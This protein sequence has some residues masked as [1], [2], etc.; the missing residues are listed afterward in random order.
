MDETKNLP[1]TEG[2]RQPALGSGSSS[3]ETK[4]GIPAVI[5]RYRVLGHLGEGGFDGSI[6]LTTTSESWRT[7]WS[8]F[9]MSE[10]GNGHPMVILWNR[11][12]GRYLNRILSMSKA[13][14]M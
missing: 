14:G 5:G 6:W 10:L 8:H 9:R 13:H 12:S 1:E 11:S 2:S 7:N 3:D 4:S